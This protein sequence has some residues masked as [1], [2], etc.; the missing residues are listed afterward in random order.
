MPTRS[1]ITAGATQRC[2]VVEASDSRAV[3]VSAVA[4]TRPSSRD[5]STLG[6]R[7]RGSTFVQR[8]GADRWRASE[9]SPM[10]PA[11]SVAGRAARAEGPR[12]GVR[13]ART[14]GGAVDAAAVDLVGRRA[15]FVLVCA[16]LA[17]GVL[18][19][20]VPVLSSDF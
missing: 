19:R 15:L 11:E 17:L 7:M 20:S 4:L 9:R 10:L 12:G 5:H 2:H 14:S 1:T 6:D 8:V 18:L 3:L 16:A 13:T